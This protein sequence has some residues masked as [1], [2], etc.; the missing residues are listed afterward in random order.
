MK[1]VSIILVTHKRLGHLSKLLEQV[2]EQFPSSEVIVVINGDASSQYDDLR[3]KY[4]FIWLE[5]SFETPGL[6]RNYG[7]S[8]S[9]RKWL[10][11]LDDDI[12]LPDDFS[13]KA[14]SILERTT[15]KIVALGG[16][17]QQPPNSNFFSR[18]LS[19][20]LTSP[21]ATAHTRLRHTKTMGSIRSGDESNL[22]LCNLWVKKN[23]IV[24][25]KIL[26]NKNLFRNEEN[27]L[28]E[29]I[30]QAGGEAEYHPELSIY[31]YRKTR[32]DSLLKAVFSSGKHRIKSIIFNRKLFNF[33]FL[34][35]SI[36]VLY[37]LS[38]FFYSTVPYYLIPLKLY[39]SL[40]LFISFK[41]CAKEALLWPLV[42]FYQIF[43]NIFYGLGVIYGLLCWP[44][45]IFS[46][47]K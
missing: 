24:D 18:A 36:W 3:K 7:L 30:L 22:I 45:W 19:L 23:F 12:T 6:A 9:Q 10:L 17:D 15:D 46:L 38:L 31:H 1:D 26:C 5:G 44:F 33:L 40:S 43:L 20:A 41:I 34:I 32:L 39:L 16:H 28:I 35:P 47:R 27:L 25:N 2:V 29:E 11:F 8:K 14:V 13:K 37:I 4:S 42:L 21:M